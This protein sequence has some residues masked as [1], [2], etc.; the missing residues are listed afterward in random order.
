MLM[1]EFRFFPETKFQNSRGLSLPPDV[2]ME[3]EV[4]AFM[5]ESR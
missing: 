3:D 1:Y 4:D 2:G 5:D